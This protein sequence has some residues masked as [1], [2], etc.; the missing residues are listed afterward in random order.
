MT[1]P[2]ARR[3]DAYKASEVEWLGEVPNAWNVVRIKG[4]FCRAKSSAAFPAKKPC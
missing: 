3:Y 4:A 2:V 1:V